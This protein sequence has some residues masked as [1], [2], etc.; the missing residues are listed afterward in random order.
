[1]AAEAAG[2]QMILFEPPVCIGINDAINGVWLPKTS[3]PNAPTPPASTNPLGRVFH[4]LTFNR[5]YH[6]YVFSLLNPV[7]GNKMAVEGV[8]RMIRQGL[9]AGTVSW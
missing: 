6:N 8:L 2:S 1:M 3:G 9:I 4:N 5:R 7:R